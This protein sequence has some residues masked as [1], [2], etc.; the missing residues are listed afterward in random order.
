VVYIH[1]VATKEYRP[2]TRANETGKSRR[3]IQRGRDRAARRLGDQAYAEYAAST[4]HGET[5][6]KDEGTARIEGARS[7]GEDSNLNVSY[8]PFATTAG[9]HPINSLYRTL[10]V[11]LK[12]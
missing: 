2:P 1:G 7:Q 4:T 5:R 9:L 3:S 10:M 11:V 12:L 8:S 6:A